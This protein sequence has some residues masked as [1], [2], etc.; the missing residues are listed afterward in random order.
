MIV[1]LLPVFRDGY[2]QI[3][4]EFVQSLETVH[5]AIEKGAGGSIRAGSCRGS[6]YCSI[7]KGQENRV[8]QRK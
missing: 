2:E 1:L 3:P 6:G 8:I 5:K 7:K 4:D